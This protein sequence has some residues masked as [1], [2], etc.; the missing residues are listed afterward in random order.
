VCCCSP[1]FPEVRISRAAVTCIATCLRGREAPE[2]VHQGKSGGCAQ[3]SSGRHVGPQE[4]L[5]GDALLFVCD[6]LL[7]GV[8]QPSAKLGRFSACMKVCD[9]VREGVE[10]GHAKDD[11][12]KGVEGTEVQEEDRQSGKWGI[13]GHRDE[14]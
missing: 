6:S 5:F 8:L 12:A 9:D 1:L 3:G 13:V 4:R 14:E 7:H 11:A 10:R 2:D